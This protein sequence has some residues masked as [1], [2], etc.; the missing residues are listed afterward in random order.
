[1]SVRKKQYSGC[2]GGGGRRLRFIQTPT[3]NEE[4]LSS[5]T[6]S[7]YSNDRYCSFSR[8]RWKKFKFMYV[9]C[10]HDMMSGIDIVTFHV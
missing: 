3:A 9:M 7:I 4:S 5:D 2:S 8:S 10:F 1:M 6:L